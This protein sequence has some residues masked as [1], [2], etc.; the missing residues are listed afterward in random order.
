M[1]RRAAGAARW[2]VTVGPILRELPHVEDRLIDQL[3]KTLR[4]R[5]PLH[6]LEVAISSAGSGPAAMVRAVL[7]V[8]K[9]WPVEEW[10]REYGKVTTAAA[11]QAQLSVAER[12]G[13]HRVE[14]VKAE[15]DESA[16]PRDEGGKFSGG[17]GGASSGSRTP[18]EAKQALAALPRAWHSQ[19]QV[20][21]DSL[22]DT[23]IP[24]VDLDVFRG[25][26]ADGKASSALVP[27]DRNLIAT[28][29]TVRAS[30]VE[31]LLDT[32]ADKWNLTD[33]KSSVL[34]A[35]VN[36]K[37]YLI[38][39]HHRAAAAALLGRP[40]I[41]ASV[42]DLGDHPE[43]AR[44]PVGYGRP[45]NK[46]A[47][48][49]VLL[50][51]AAPTVYDRAAR[52]AELNAASLAKGLT[53]EQTAAIRAVI[54]SALRGNLTVPQVA[55]LI[56]ETIG[57]NE[58]YARAVV[59]L[60]DSLIEEGAD[61]ARIQR[62]TGK[63]A[64]R[65]RRGRAETIART[66]TMRAMNAGTEEGWRDAVE[67][68]LIDKETTRRIWIASPDACEDCSFM[69]GE[70]TRVDEPWDTEYGPIDTPQDMHPNCRCSE[71]LEFGVVEEG[72]E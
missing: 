15:W 40:A 4:E 6:E 36:G 28:Q 7:S 43:L 18:A 5:A 11:K 26:I 65:L 3:D 61:P 70:M 23:D 27:L 17:G 46:A 12:K 49:A 10:V 69:D 35:V 39:G 1:A 55:R 8:L 25:A 47:W 53:E 14:L 50:D 59:A 51:K 58:R 66:E 31:S 72:A 44:K 33:P 9:P 13:A 30:K 42:I 52:I 32:T 37:R 22:F 64:T 62:E 67:S 57:L 48:R 16:H 54:S 38:D 2:K 71:G 19:G 41:R 68:D 20:D 21:L 45:V 34:V 60:N 24:P 56:Q 29:G 63:Y